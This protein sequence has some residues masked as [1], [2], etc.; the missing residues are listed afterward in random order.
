MQDLLV[1]CDWGDYAMMRRVGPRCAFQ[2]NA[3]P[4]LDV[5]EAP[6]GVLSGPVDQHLWLGTLGKVEEREGERKETEELAHTSRDHTSVSSCPIFLRTLT[7]RTVVM[8]VGGYAKTPDFLR[9]V[10]VVTGVPQCH[11]YCRVNGTA[12]PEGN[13]ARGPQRD[14]I[15]MVSARL[16]GGASVPDEWF[17]QVCERGWCRPARLD[18]FRCGCKQGELLAI[19]HLIKVLLWSV[20]GWSG[21]HRKELVSQPLGNMAGSV[22]IEELDDAYLGLNHLD[23]QNSTM[24]VQGEGCFFHRCPM[25][26][27]A[28]FFQI[29]CFDTSQSQCDEL[30]SSRS[31]AEAGSCSCP[32]IQS[33]W[34]LQVQVTFH[35]LIF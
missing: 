34:L 20:R 33:C 13:A 1:P 7:S 22:I 17:C 19:A 15:V 18:C 2:E 5:A 24:A 23:V 28:L 16:L 32:C 3:S 10:E 6:I 25:A 30:G 31:F 29:P 21:R 27:T 26:Q 4:R 11:W 35:L 8:D 12:L 9:R 14:S